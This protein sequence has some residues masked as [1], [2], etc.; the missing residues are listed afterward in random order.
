MDWALLI[1]LSGVGL[2][3][4]IIYMG[5]IEKMRKRELLH[6]EITH[7]IEKGVDVPMSSQRNPL[8]YLRKGII[9]GLIGF[10]I[11]LAFIIDGD[12]EA[13]GVLGSIPFSVGIGYIIYYKL[14]SQQNK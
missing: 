7:A 4:F 12:I 2:V 9:W 11:G 6:K 5:T 8:D 1:P 13:A 14:A 3:A 10:L